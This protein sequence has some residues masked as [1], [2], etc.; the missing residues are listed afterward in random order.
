MTLYDDNFGHWDRPDDA[1]TRDFYAQVQRTNVS[2]VCAGCK[3]KVR[4][5]A[6]YAYCNAGADASEGGGDF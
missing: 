4:I 5:Q 1:D 2:K 6:H 3:R